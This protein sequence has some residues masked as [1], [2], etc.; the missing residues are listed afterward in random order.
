M[1]GQLGSGLLKENAVLETQKVLGNRLLL[2]LNL[3]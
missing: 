3:Y 2:L 1:G